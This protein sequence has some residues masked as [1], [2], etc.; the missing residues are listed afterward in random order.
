[1]GNAHEVLFKYLAVQLNISSLRPFT[2]DSPVI[3]R[4]AAPQR[5]VCPSQ[6]RSELWDT[7]VNTK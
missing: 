1:M 4:C 7:E 2:G 3:D 5:P 6:W